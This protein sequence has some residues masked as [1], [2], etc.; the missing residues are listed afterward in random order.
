MITLQ[1]SRHPR[2][3][4]VRPTYDSGILIIYLLKKSDAVSSKKHIKFNIPSFCENRIN[5]R[6]GINKLFFRESRS[7]EGESERKMSW[8]AAVKEEQIPA[9]QET[10]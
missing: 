10:G 5:W 2:V 4:P 7:F 1:S 9:L 3:S 8:R 6:K